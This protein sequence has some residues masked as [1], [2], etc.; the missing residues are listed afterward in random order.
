MLNMTLAQALQGMLKVKLIT[1]RD[2]PTNPN[3]ASHQYNPNARCAYHSDSPGHDTNN[4]WPLKDKIQDMIDAG[5]IEFDPPETPNVI[6][7][8]KS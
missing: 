6:T 7:A 2:P 4:C 3:T 1:L 8:P 5:E